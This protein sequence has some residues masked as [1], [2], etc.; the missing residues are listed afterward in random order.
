MACQN[1]GC[2]VTE[3]QA[4]PWP[5]QGGCRFQLFPRVFEQGHDLMTHQWSLKLQQ[6]RNTLA[7]NAI[8]KCTMQTRSDLHT[9][10]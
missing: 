8:N 10:F 4:L 9:C 2:N 6:Q 7:K 1:S 3:L 5:V